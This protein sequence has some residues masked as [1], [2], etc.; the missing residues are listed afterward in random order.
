MTEATWRWDGVWVVP[1]GAPLVAAAQTAGV[2]RRVA[3]D[4]ARVE[5]A[6]PWSVSTGFNELSEVAIASREGYSPDRP[7]SV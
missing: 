4:L 1:G 6:K 2:D 7:S 3:I 5:V